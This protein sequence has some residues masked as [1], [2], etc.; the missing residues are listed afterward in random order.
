MNNNYELYYAV[1]DQEQVDEFTYNF[2]ADLINKYVKDHQEEF[3]KWKDYEHL[4][5][6]VK[7][8]LDVNKTVSFKQR[9]QLLHQIK[10]EF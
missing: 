3:K 5:N 6:V 4:K 7:N 1:M 8:G 2:T 10:E 9:K